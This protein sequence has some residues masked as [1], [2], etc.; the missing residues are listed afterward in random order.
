M[1]TPRTL[2][3]RAWRALARPIASSPAA[4][5]LTTAVGA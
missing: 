2:G 3:R 4:V 5:G 1:T